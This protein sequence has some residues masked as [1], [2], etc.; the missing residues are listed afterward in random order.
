MK[1]TKP[2]PRKTTVLP[3]REPAKPL[4][5]PELKP[6][7][8]SHP[9]SLIFREVL[10]A[11]AKL[12]QSAIAPPTIERPAIEL[13]TIVQTTIEQPAIA[14]NTTVEPFQPPTSHDATVESPAIAQHAIAPDAFTR[15]PNGILDRVLP[16]LSAYDQLV[17]LRLYR[18][19]RGFGKEECTVGYQTLAVAC[20]MSARQ[21]QISVERLIL[22]GWIERVD[23]VQGGQSRQGRGSVYRVN[24]PAAATK[25]RG[26]I[27]QGAIA[28]SATNKDKDIN[29]RIKRGSR[30][31]DYSD[32]PDCEGR[33]Y[34]WPEGYEK[35]VAKCK[36]KRMV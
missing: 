31:R 28:G 33:G 13:D 11:Q 22:A 25:E 36:H 21:A 20:N 32:C 30:A 2:Q 29:E 24:L 5:Q 3:L 19:S 14:Q 34:W 12:E 1:N 16:T 27:A 15:I 18:L 9:A 10:D 26:A 7:D 23:M 6:P 35:G 4:V 17:L 8:P